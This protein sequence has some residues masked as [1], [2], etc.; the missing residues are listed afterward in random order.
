MIDTN[1]EKLWSKRQQNIDESNVREHKR[2]PLI[3]F[4]LSSLNFFSSRISCWMIC[5]RTNIWHINGNRSETVIITF[6]EAEVRTWWNSKFCIFVWTMACHNYYVSGWKSGHL[7]E[8]FTLNS[9]HL[10][11]NPSD[12]DVNVKH[13]KRLD[14]FWNLIES[15]T[16]Y[17]TACRCAPYC[18][19]ELL[20]PVTHIRPES[21][22]CAW[23]VLNFRPCKYST[24][25]CIEVLVWGKKDLILLV[26]ATYC[27][28]MKWNCWHLLLY[29]SA[30]GQFTRKT[31]TSSAFLM[32]SS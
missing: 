16:R 20:R 12:F 6:F 30:Q 22:L 14:L 15:F 18:E 3:A 10:K 19:V 29:Y 4:P 31:P 24:E 9:T 25:F 11:K 26:E 5:F 17:S 13:Q 1:K 27:I 8:P 2:T 32:L 23:R 28:R 21:H 7:E